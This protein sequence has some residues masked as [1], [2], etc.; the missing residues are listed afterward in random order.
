MIVAAG[1]DVK[2]VQRRLG[3]ASL[4]MTLGLY[5]KVVQSGDGRAAEALDALAG[6]AGA[7]GSAGNPTD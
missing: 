1:V 2:T 4:A 7:E 5:A 3:H 6:D